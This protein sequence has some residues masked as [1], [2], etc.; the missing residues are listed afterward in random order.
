M[1]NLH[2]SIPVRP[3]L[4]YAAFAPF[5]VKAR[6]CPLRKTDLYWMARSFALLFGHF[7]EGFRL[8]KLIIA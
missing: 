1:P 5:C 8:S 3:V 6:Q 7:F 2:T 4:S